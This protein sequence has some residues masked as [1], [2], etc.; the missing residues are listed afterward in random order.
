MAGELLGAFGSQHSPL[1]EADLLS[2]WPS[3]TEISHRV[4]TRHCGR[5][6][7]VP[8]TPMLLWFPFTYRI[9]FKP[10]RVV[11]GGDGTPPGGRSDKGVTVRRA[12]QTTKQVEVPLFYYYHAPAIVDNVSNKYSSSP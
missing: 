11:G 7:A 10:T 12:R 5:E 6:R 1:L 9:K 3:E 2:E 8:A 4:R